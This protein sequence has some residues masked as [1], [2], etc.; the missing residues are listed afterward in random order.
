MFILV[1]DVNFR[2][3]KNASAYLV[4]QLLCTEPEDVVNLLL[5]QVG[6]AAAA[7]HAGL[8][9]RYKG[10]VGIRTCQFQT[11]TFS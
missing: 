10:L 2:S 4:E 7:A 3:Y 8:K 1:Q 5:G 6:L 9:E 11:I